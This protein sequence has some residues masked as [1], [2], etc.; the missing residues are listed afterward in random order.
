MRLLLVIAILVASL[1]FT[2]VVKAADY[3]VD[4]ACQQEMVLGH[5]DAP[6][7]SDEPCHDCCLHSCGHVLLSGEAQSTP[8]LT[9][10]QFR[11]ADIPA[12]HG[13]EPSGLLRPPR[14]A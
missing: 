12:L 10:S 7:N 14:A 8:T 5:D 13:L 4:H 1:S 9:A 3:C 2:G 6:A 11:A